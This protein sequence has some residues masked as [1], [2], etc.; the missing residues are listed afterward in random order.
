[1]GRGND[2]AIRPGPGER[3]PGPLPPDV[4]R[5]R[6]DPLVALQAQDNGQA[7]PG[8]PGGVP[9]EKERTFRQPTLRRLAPQKS[10]Y[11][12]LGFLPELTFTSAQGNSTL[13]LNGLDAVRRDCI[14]NADPGGWFLCVAIPP[15]SSPLH[16][17]SPP[18]SLI[19]HYRPLPP[20]DGAEVPLDLH[21]S[22]PRH[23]RFKPR[24]PRAEA[25]LEEIFYREFGLAWKEVT[26]PEVPR[27][28]VFAHFGPDLGNKSPNFPIALAACFRDEQTGGMTRDEC[29]SLFA[30]RF[31]EPTRGMTRGERA[32]LYARQ[33][34]QM[35]LFPLVLIAT[36]DSRWIERR[37]VGLRLTTWGQTIE[38]ETWSTISHEEDGCYTY[39]EVNPYFA[40]W[41][42]EWETFV[43]PGPMPPDLNQFRD[44][45]R[46]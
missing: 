44:P 41:L 26:S 29:E 18:M 25:A 22:R 28:V 17:Q 23:F 7:S 33:L 5:V 6:L 31:G 45:M 2:Q 24:F 21:D 27:G 4:G 20:D 19:V 37:L 3:L 15:R 30:W 14:Q 32:S 13:G 11:Q 8:C 12:A 10:L 34:A 35:P 39:R 38:D 9:G 40:A 42:W 36:A 43:P 1:M 16:T 46:V